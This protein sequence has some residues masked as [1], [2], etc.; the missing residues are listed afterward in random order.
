MTAKTKTDGTAIKK[1]A[2]IDAYSKTFGNITEACKAIGVSRNTFYEY[3][4]LDPKFKE[5]IDN[6]EPDEVFI[7]FAFNALAERISKGDTTAIIFALKTKG[8]KRGFI[9]R[10]EF[11]HLSDGKQIKIILPDGV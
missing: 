7:D 2:F 8:K 3:M 9:E 6:A 5:A 10:S 1:K 4:K 11:D